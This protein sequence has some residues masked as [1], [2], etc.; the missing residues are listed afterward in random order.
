MFT[1]QH[2]GAKASA[3]LARKRAIDKYYSD[4]NHC[5][6]CDHIITVEANQRVPEVRKKKFC[7]QSCAAV[8][9][10]TKSPK[11]KRA[12]KRFCPCGK[13][14]QSHNE[15]CGRCEQ[16]RRS[17]L[18]SMSKGD[19]FRR[20]R[21]WQTARSSITYHANSVYDRLGKL[22]QCAECGYGTHYEICHIRSVASFPEDALISEINAITNLVPLCP[23]HH[24]EF[25]NGLLSHDSR[26][27][28]G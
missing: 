24:W 2:L 3:L 13:S 1:F 20:Y 11:R 23:N 19:V 26:W 10:N 28:S 4:P 17:I 12:E 14:I 18:G 6:N 15:L 27:S 25:D 21:T 5:Q 8:F 16:A 22:R 7:N 9:N